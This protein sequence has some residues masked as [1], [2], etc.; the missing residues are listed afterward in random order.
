MRP[1]GVEAVHAASTPAN[2]T[3]DTE[4]NPNRWVAE[5]EQEEEEGND[6]DASSDEENSDSSD[7]S[8]DQEPASEKAN[9]DARQHREKRHSNQTKNTTNTPKRLNAKTR[10]RL[11]MKQLRK[12]PRGWGFLMEDVSRSVA[13]PRQST[14]GLQV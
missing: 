1:E 8:S 3:L 10:R 2:P 6:N 4:D 7:D 13:H 11:E 5:E 14:H 12:L 9:K